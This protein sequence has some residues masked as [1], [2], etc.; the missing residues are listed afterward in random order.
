[1]IA[2]AVVVIWVGSI[3]MYGRAIGMERQKHVWRDIRLH[4]GRRSR[5]VSKQ[6]SLEVSRKQPLE[7]V[8]S[9]NGHEVV[10]TIVPTDPDTHKLAIGVKLTPPD[11]QVRV[12]LLSADGVR[13][14]LPLS[15]NGTTSLPEVTPGAYEL[16][17]KRGEA[18]IL[19]CISVAIEVGSAVGSGP[20]SR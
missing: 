2:A 18:D 3:L 6:E 4:S 16:V 13:Q 9:Q 17:L 7:L 8:R 5:E 10:V 20:P 19:E 15:R 14:H 1:M 12:T 11:R